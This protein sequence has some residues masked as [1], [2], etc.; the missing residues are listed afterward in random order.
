MEAR[1]ANEDFS[2]ADLAAAVFLERTQ[3]FRKLKALTGLTPTLFIRRIRLQR[4][5]TALR[6]PG[7]TVAQ[8]AYAH[9]FRDPAYFARVFREEFGLSPSGSRK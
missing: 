3:L 4:A 5:R 2:V 9:G 7:I 1:L 6:E 8:V